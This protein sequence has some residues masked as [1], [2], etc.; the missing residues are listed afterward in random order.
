MYMKRVIDLKKTG[1]SALMERRHRLRRRQKEIYRYGF[2]QGSKR[3][4]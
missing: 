3:I 2:T 1:A 4:K